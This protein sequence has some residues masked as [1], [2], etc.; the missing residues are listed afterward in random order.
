LKKNGIIYAIGQDHKVLDP[1]KITSG[2]AFSIFGS[3]QSFESIL[4]NCH[5]TDNDSLL[6]S[7][8]NLFLHFVSNNAEAFIDEVA[9]KNGFDRVEILLFIRNPFSHA[10]SF[11]QQ[12][13]KRGGGYH[14]SL[15][16]FN[17]F[18][19]D[20]RYKIFR[21]LNNFWKKPKRVS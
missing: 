19:T 6:F 21:W 9:L 10:E 13:I 3:R 17:Q 7:S 18:E 20:L 8:E 15:D 12:Q 4:E 1:N 5:S 14:I 2:N 11:W 16:S